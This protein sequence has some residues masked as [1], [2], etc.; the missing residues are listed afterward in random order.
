MRGLTTI[1]VGAFF[2]LTAIALSVILGTTASMA[3]TNYRIGTPAVQFN[4]NSAYQMPQCT[5]SSNTYSLLN[6]LALQKNG[7]WVVIRFYYQSGD[8]GA[9][10][11]FSTAQ[12][13]STPNGYAP[14]VY[15]GTNGYLYFGDY[16][17]GV[18]LQVSFPLTPGWHTLVAGEYF[19]GGT[20]YV[21]ACLDSASNCQSDSTTN[22]PQLFST[23]SWSYGDI[24]TEYAGGGW[25]NTNHNWFFYTGDI[26]YIALYAGNTTTLE[27]DLT[28]WLNSTGGVNPPPN[29]GSPYGPYALYTTS[30]FSGNTW[31]DASGNGNAATL[32]SG[33][34]PAQLTILTQ[35]LGFGG[36]APPLQT[37]KPLI[38]AIAVLGF[39][40]IIIGA[41]QALIDEAS[42]L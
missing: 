23:G 34:Q 41:V 2:V 26:E 18:F 19:S 6:C 37:L 16:A 1:A 12:Y 11:G 24:G 33:T 10:L 15:I 31:F 36:A 30:S 21:Y 42:R 20:Y 14:W 28:N 38:T 25:V 7:T 8:E 29:L 13:P 5:I 27:N 40:I 9:I 17:S 4:N 35:Q 39:L 3:N 32:V 22:L